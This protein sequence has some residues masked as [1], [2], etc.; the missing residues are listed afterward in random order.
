MSNIERPGDL[1]SICMQLAGAAHQSLGQKRGPAGLILVCFDHG[2]NGQ[3]SWSSSISAEDTLQ[4]MRQVA[5]LM[6]K[7]LAQ[8]LTPAPEPPKEESRIIQP[9]ATNKKEVG[10]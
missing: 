8:A 1:G 3:I 5:E 7:N 10:H 4:L 2:V 6:E 9:F